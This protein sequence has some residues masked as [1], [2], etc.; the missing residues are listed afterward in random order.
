MESEYQTKRAGLL[1]MINHYRNQCFYYLG[2][3]TL[4]LDDLKVLHEYDESQVDKYQA[5]LLLL[6]TKKDLE[7]ID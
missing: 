2:E 4:L 3:T 6:D 1:Y 7:L 5:D